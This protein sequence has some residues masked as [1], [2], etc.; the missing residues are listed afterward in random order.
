VS[1]GHEKLL[2]EKRVETLRNWVSWK[3]RRVIASVHEDRARCVEVKD[4]Q[5]SVC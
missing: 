4:L 1:G 5:G 3:L 2:K